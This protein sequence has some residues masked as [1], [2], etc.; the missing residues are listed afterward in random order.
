MIAVVIEEETVNSKQSISQSVTG[1]QLC[2]SV[3]LALV[4]GL[5]L[6][7]IFDP[8]LTPYYERDL[9]S[10]PPAYCLS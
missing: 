10:L 3:G 4:F 8:G 1:C 2:W 5:L 9:S 7:L 6:E